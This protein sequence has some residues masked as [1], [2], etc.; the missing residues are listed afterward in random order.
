[1]KSLVSQ[2][3]K[4]AEVKRDS[5]ENSLQPQ[6]ERAAEEGDARAY[7]TAAERRATVPAIVAL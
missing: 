5:P 6:D 2:D 4:R 7:A 3:R 1:L